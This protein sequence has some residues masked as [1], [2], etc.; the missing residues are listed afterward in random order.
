MKQKKF[1]FKNKKSTG[2][3]SWL[4]PNTHYIK[5]NGKK[6]GY[7][8]DVEPYKINLSIKKEETETEPA[9]FKWITLKKESK[10]LQE[11]KD[12]LNEYIEQILE[13]YDLYMFDE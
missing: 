7:I 1:T 10:S 8:K 6:V 13:K 5:L 4:D 9:P 2:R 3:Y 11:A 12:F